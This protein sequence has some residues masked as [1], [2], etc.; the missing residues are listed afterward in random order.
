[1]NATAPRASLAHQAY[2]ALEQ[3]IV[4]GRLAPGLWLTEAEIGQQL[5]L[6]RTPVREALQRLALEHMVEIVPRR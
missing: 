6:G 3:R 2:L 4:T 1:M 5:G